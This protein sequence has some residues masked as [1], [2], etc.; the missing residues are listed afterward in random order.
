MDITLSITE[1]LTYYDGPDIVVLKNSDPVYAIG[2]VV[3]PDEGPP[4]IFAIPVDQ[5][6]VNRFA[7]GKLGLKQL[8]LDTSEQGWYLCKTYDMS[9]EMVFTINYDEPIP[10]EYLLQE[11]LFLIQHDEE[12]PTTT[13]FEAELEHL[14]DQL[15]NDPHEVSRT[16][17]ASLDEYAT[18]IS[19]F[20]ITRQ[21]SVKAQLEIYETQDN[22][23]FLLNVVTFLQAG[24]FESTIED[25]NKKANKRSLDPYDQFSPALSYMSAETEPVV[26]IKSNELASYSSDLSKAPFKTYFCT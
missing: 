8:M 18:R 10:S 4:E 3:Y 1:V 2:T 17:Q 7:N 11:E 5:E 16:I 9:E 14:E 23:S 20:S 13:E 12:H 15:A 22:T 24:A 26:N 19:Q 25:M 6:E 21:S